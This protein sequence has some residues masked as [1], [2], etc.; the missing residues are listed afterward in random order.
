MRDATRNAE[1]SM[2]ALGVHVQALQDRLELARTPASDVRVDDVPA[3]LLL[4]VANA[5]ETLEQSIE[6]VLDRIDPGCGRGARTLA[7]LQR[8]QV[9]RVAAPPSAATAKS[10]DA[11]TI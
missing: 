11:A 4:H 3:E 7:G 10:R 9:P 2:R 8:R 1:A 6:R 5:A